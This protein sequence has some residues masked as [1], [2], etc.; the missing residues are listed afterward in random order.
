MKAE[1]ERKPPDDL[2]ERLEEWTGKGVSRE[3]LGRLQRHVSMLAQW[4]VAQNLVAPRTLGAIWERHVLDSA[5]ILRIVPGARTVCDLGSGAGFPGLVL[6]ILLTDRPGAHVH[7]VESN[8]R[9]VAFLRAV[10]RETGA[11]ATIH[12]SRI[13]ELPA[14][15]VGPVDVVT[16]RA[17]APLDRLFAWSAPLLT[18]GATAVFH[19]GAGVEGEIQ[20]AAHA[21]RFDLVRHRSLTDPEGRILVI[22]NLERL[23]EETGA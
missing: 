20:R 22:R 23:G 17:L 6:A 8:R 13:E 15:R 7:L 18:G 5:Q 11:P 19:K 2:R 14:D 9:K 3:T 21:W 1:G 12:A 16:A 10:A 4:Q